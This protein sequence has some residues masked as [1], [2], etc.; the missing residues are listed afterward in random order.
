M[1]MQADDWG[2]YDASWRM[3]ELGSA[4]PVPRSSYQ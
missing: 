2:S 1:M 3:K 4:L